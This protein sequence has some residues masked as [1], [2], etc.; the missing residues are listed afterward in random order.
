[1]AVQDRDRVL[2]FG[3][4][5]FETLDRLRRE[6]NFRD[7][8]NRAATARERRG[9]CLQIN[10]GLAAAGHAVQQN[11]AR[12]LRRME[13]F[14]DLLQGKD[15]LFIQLKIRCGDK[16]LIAVR[17]AYH[18]LLAQLGEAAFYQPAQ[19]LVIQRHLAQQL[20][21]GNGRVEPADCLEQ[22]RLTRSAPPEL[23]VFLIVDLAR[24][25]HEQLFLPTDLRASNHLR[26]QTA[27][28]RFDRAAIVRAHPVSQLEQFFAQD[29]RFAYDRFD[30]ANPFRFALL[31]RRHH[32]AERRFVAKWHA[33]TRP[34]ADALRQCFGHEI[35]ELAMDRAVDDYPN[36]AGLYHTITLE[37][38]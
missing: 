8:H 26:Q 23:F 13:R 22:F 5:T 7:E 21:G 11:R 25:L 35:V 17:I 37:F 28:D 20:R 31:K 24:G 32:G 12:T 15:L 1:M 36:V 9:N 18:S 14:R 16:L 38:N 33:H 29:W 10:F 2:R 30:R 3:E 4:A 34:D 19:G 6:R 27:H